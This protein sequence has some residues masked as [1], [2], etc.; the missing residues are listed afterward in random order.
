MNINY[1]KSIF[2]KAL[3]AGIT[4]GIGGI[5]YVLVENKYLGAVLFSLGLFTIMQ[6]KFALYTGKV[7]YIPQN[8]PSYIIEVLVTF[9]GNVAGTAF[10]AL[11]VGQTRLGNKIEQCT[12]EIM[13]AKID[14]TVISKLIL[15]FFCGILMY[16]AVENNQI[17]RKNNYDMSAVFG[18]VFPV[19]VFILCGFN[20]SI[21]DCFY[22]FSA[23]VS[24]PGVLYILTVAL[25]NAVGGMLISTMSKIPDKSTKES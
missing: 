8:K 15:G 18:T 23:G 13:Q 21:A 3:T 10:T 5:V 14:D 4:I 6:F 9:A 2:L 17:S 25:G 1:I 16:I 12:S 19:A 7:G 20:H 11:M 24:L 22:M